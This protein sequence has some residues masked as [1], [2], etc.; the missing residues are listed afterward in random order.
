MRIQRYYPVPIGN[1]IVWL[2][3]FSTKLPVHATELEL[4]PA[5]VAARVLDVANALYALLNY[6]GSVAN[7]PKAAYEC[8]DEVLHATGQAG[9]VSWFS[10]TP[11]P[12]A[13]APVAYGC[14]DR[15]FAFISDVIKKAARYSTAIGLDLGIEIHATP[16]PSH[17]VSPDFT[18]RFTNGKKM[19]VVWPKLQFDGVKLE[20]HLGAA[21]MRT[22]MDLRPNYTL[23]WLPPAGQSAIIRVRAR[24]IYKGED[25]GQWSAWQDWTLTGV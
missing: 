4:D 1:Q 2:R 22:D 14:L 3:N 10:F 16:A 25:F 8:I 11:P 23:D 20:F 18:L 7:F 24:Y 13:P 19:E 9:S 15:V 21:G 6:R 5:D 12:G 17:L